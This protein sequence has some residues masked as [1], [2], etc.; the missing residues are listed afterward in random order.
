VES[1]KTDLTV[2]ENGVTTIIAWQESGR[3]GR[4]EGNIGQWVDYFSALSQSWMKTL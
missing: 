3:Q 2:V 4:I 1:E